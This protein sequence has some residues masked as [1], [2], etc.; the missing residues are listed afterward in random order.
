[1]PKYNIQ[2]SVD[3]IKNYCHHDIKGIEL[4]KIVDEINCVFMFVNIQ[5]NNPRYSNGY[6]SIKTCVEVV[7]W[8]CDESLFVLEQ[9]LRSKKCVSYVDKKTIDY[10]TTKILYATIIRSEFTKYFI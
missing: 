10:S 2:L 9:Y 3:D 6:D 4:N 7:T 5:L 1:M 8:V